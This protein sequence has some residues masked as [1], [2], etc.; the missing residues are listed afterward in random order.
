MKY[1]PTSPGCHRLLTRGLVD[2]CGKQGGAVGFQL[3]DV[4][5]LCWADGH[6]TVPRKLT[7][8]KASQA[9]FTVKK[10]STSCG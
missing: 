7:V 2:K 10:F 4:L 1:S 6:E 5:D 3:L 9:Y 8:G